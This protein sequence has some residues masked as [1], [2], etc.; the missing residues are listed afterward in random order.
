MFSNLLLTMTVPGCRPCTAMSRTILACA[1]KFL[2]RVSAPFLSHTPQ[3]PLFTPRP[4][5]LSC[6]PSICQHNKQRNTPHNPCDSVPCSALECLSAT[7]VCMVPFGAYAAHQRA[8]RHEENRQSTA[9]CTD[10]IA[11]TA[12]STHCAEVCAIKSNAHVCID[13]G[14]IPDPA[15]SSRPEVQRIVASLSTKA[16]VR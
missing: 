15:M 8:S 10:S 14:H 5:L 2:M 3:A 12:G 4:P 1:L 7:T 9:V 13:D 11:T 16:L 6:R